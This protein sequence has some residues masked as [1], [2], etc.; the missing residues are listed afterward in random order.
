MAKPTDV[1]VVGGGV[2]GCAAALELAKAGLRVTLI[3]RGTPGCEASGAAAGMLAPQAESSAPSPFLGLARESQALYPD[4]A[5]E[6]RDETGVDIE[7]QAQGNLFCFL[8]EGDQALG[9]SAFEWQ[10]EA[11]L[12]AEL[13]SREDALR[14]EPELSS[15]IRGALFMAEDSWVNNVKLVGALA[16][17]ASVRGVEFLRGEVTGVAMSGSRVVGAR[18]SGETLKA[19]AVLLAAGAWSGGILAASGLSLPVEPVRGQILSL[20]SA[21][22][23]LRRLIHVK[24]HYLVP[25]VGGEVLVGASMER[26]GFSREV[27][28]GQISALLGS[29]L[30]A[31]PGLAGLPLAAMWSGFRPGTPDERPILGRYPGVEDLYVATGHFRNGILLAPITAR[32]MRELIVDGAPSL[33]LTPF[34]PDRFVS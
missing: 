8:D 2:I 27:T 18:L 5:V 10:R 7:L 24:E 33:D 31:V 9:R 32:L 16:Q 15:E 19:G 34:L 11:G 22:R 21:P 1:L 12:K 13:L 23:K 6:L 30:R 29:A 26:V 28:A 3:E 20:H 17:A 25:R 4:L 14:I